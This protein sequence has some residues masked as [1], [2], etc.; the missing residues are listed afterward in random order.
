MFFKRKPKKLKQ[1]EIQAI[2]KKLAFPE[3]VIICPKCGKQLEYFPIG[4]AAE[5]RC[6]SRKCIKGSSMGIYVSL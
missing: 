1:P 2:N 6:P 4:N 3:Q 5:V